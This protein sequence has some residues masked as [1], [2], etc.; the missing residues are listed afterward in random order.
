MARPQKIGLSY[1]PLDIDFFNDI[2]IRKLIKYQGSRSIAIYTC[3]LCSIYKN[4]YYIKWDK[5]MP[6]V[7]SEITGE[8]ENYITDVVNCSVEIN[9]FDENFFKNKKILTSIGIQNRFNSISKQSKRKFFTSEFNLVSSEET[10]VNSEETIL[11][12]EETIVIS[13]KSTQSKVKKRKVK[14]NKENQSKGN[15]SNSSLEQYFEVEEIEN[16]EFFQDEN[17]TENLETKN[18]KKQKEKKVA[19]KKEKVIPTWDEFWEYQSNYMKVKLELKPSDYI[20]SSES[21]YQAW[22][23]NEWRDGYNN[24][25][26]DWKAK[27]RNIVPHLKE[28]K[29]NGS[30]IPIAGRQT[31]ETIA[32]NLKGWQ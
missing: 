14:E 28:I 19:T 4:G 20:I 2:K 22:F 25:I 17:E 1:F 8:D 5:D 11:N 23:D 29:P 26:L 7:I 6:F 16:Y 3:L 31:A 18:S 21:K 12:S 32:A 10:I 13:A 15:E 27:A 24:P 30:N 9:L